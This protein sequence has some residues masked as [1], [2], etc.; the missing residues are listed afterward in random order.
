MRLW[1][2]HHHRHD[3]VHPDR[4]VIG[5][6][7]MLLEQRD[8]DVEIR[9]HFFRHGKLVRSVPVSGCL[10]PVGRQDSA[11]VFQRHECASPVGCRNE[12]CHL[13]PDLVFFLVGRESKHC[14]GIRIFLVRA[15]PVSRPVSGENASCRM[16]AVEILDIYEES[17]PLR[18]IK[19]ERYFMYPFGRGY[20][21]AFTVWLCRRTVHIGSQ[22]LRLAFPPPAPV[23]LEYP[24]LYPVPF[25]AA[26]VFVYHSHFECVRSVGFEIVSAAARHPYPHIGG[27]WRK[28][29]GL[30]C[31]ALVSSAFLYR[32]HEPSFHHSGSLVQ[33]RHDDVFFCNAF[34]VEPGVEKLD[35]SLRCRDCRVIEDIPFVAF[36]GLPG[37]TEI[38][39]YFPVESVGGRSGK[40]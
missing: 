31:D 15:S 37:R 9:A 7:T 24:V 39:F 28:Q 14:Q 33:S 25:D 1:I 23:Y 20:E 16:T 11:S 6:V 5:C 18:I 35:R 10:H 40:P 13:F 30:R 17:S 12:D 2:F 36:E 26:A 19:A 32:A 34:S 21:R 27:I 22:F 3:T 29:Y 8:V 38:H 4:Q